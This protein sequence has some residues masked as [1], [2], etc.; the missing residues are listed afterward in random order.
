[1]AGSGVEGAAVD[2]E[3]RAGRPSAAKSLLIWSI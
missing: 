2:G 3:L 1:M